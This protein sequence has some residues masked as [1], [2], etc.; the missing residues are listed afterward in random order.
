MNSKLFLAAVPA[1]ILA[2]SDPAS[3]PSTGAGSGGTGNGTGGSGANA[4]GSG[5]TTTGQC[6]AGTLKLQ[7]ANDYGFSSEIKL[8]PLAVKPKSELTFDW[9]GLT[10]DFMGRPTNPTSGIDSVLL[11]VFNLTLQQLEDTLNQ[12]DGSITNKTAGALQL[13]TN[14]EVTSKSIYDFGVP[15]TPENTYRSDA[16]VKASVDEYLD[17]AI[18]DPSTH[19]IAVMPSQGTQLGKNL[20]MIQTLQLDEASS[21]ASVNIVG[22]TRVS[23]ATSGH[24]GGT[25]GPSASITYD[26]DLQ[27]LAPIGVP[28]SQP[29]LSVDWSGLTDNGLGHPWLARSISRVFVGHYS[30]TLPELEAKFLDLETIAD[31]L[32]TLDVDNDE[33]VSLTGLKNAQGQAF[34]GVDATGVWILALSCSVYCSS[35]APWYLTVL[36]PCD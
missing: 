26:V 12:D 13:L 1:L 7:A 3:S 27:H 8:T 21:T 20:R 9:S 2:C 6:S 29:A 24:S 16:S 18:N 4:G 30:Q 15:G 33:P 22:S 28:K 11:V 17:P 34:S 25:E 36:K 10:T 32:Y 23:A 31:D 14:Q 35:P 5:P 19:I